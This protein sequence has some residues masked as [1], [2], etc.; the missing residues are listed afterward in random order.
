MTRS[1]PIGRCRQLLALAALVGLCT[2]AAAAEPE[3]K[4][5]RYI[6]V[7]SAGSMIVWVARDKGFFRD[8]GIQ[9]EAA[10]DLAAGLVTDNILGGQAEM[11]YGGATAMLMP[12]AKGAPLVTIAH[13]DRTNLW[14]LIVH[15][16]SP[17]RSLE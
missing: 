8:E 17:Y 9:I 1:S 16:D 2:A 13:T 12:Y 15:G 14:E 11:V 5:I 10:N 4:T 3:V 6:A 7:P